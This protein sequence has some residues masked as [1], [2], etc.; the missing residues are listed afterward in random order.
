MSKL[1]VLIFSILVVFNAYSQ[2]KEPNAVANNEV[3]KK[4]LA[5]FKE[6][7]PNQTDVKWYPYPYQY[8]KDREVTG[9]YYPIGWKSSAPNYYEVR[10]TDDKGKIRK[11][12]NLSGQLIITSRVLSE[13]DIPPSIITQM[14]E[15]GYGD[16]KKL[17]VERVT[18]A[19]DPEK[20][21][22]IWVKK[23]KKKRIL[24]F[25]EAGRLA[26]TLKFDDEIN[27]AASENAR[28]KVAPKATKQ[29]KIASTEVPEKIRNKPK[30][31]FKELATVE[32]YLNET[33]YDPFAGPYDM[34]YYD[35]TIPIYYQVLFSKGNSFYIATYDQVG[36][37]VELAEVVK[38]KAL[39]KPIKKYFKK[40]KP[41][42]ALTEVHDK[43]E[44]E[45]GTYWYRVYGVWNNQLQMMILNE[46]GDRMDQ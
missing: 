9:V 40:V 45:D 37:F 8:G 22:K 29:R 2:K 11:V 26:K 39:P 31:Q 46:Q 13:S 15:L 41:E 44:M 35:I 18:R 12:Y 3:P 24:Y 5:A 17:M 25:N 14:N 27:F 30:D 6:K 33:V 23:D 1:S 34:V 21:L 38:T 10:F 4:I 7:H 43:V 42:I 19:G 36:E 28:F 16:W 32:W 20:Y